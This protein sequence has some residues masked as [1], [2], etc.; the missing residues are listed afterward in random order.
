M[1]DYEEKLLRDYYNTLDINAEEVP[2][3][4]LDAVIRNGIHRGGQQ[5]PFL[6]R[7]STVVVLA[8]FAAI[9]FILVPWLRGSFEPV[10][11]QL[12]PKSWGELEP[13]RPLVK[14]NITIKSALDAGLVQEIGVSSVES[15]DYVMTLDGV[16][17]DKKGI[18]AFYTFQNNSNQ[19]VVI[20]SFL[21]KNAVGNGIENQSATLI[22]N[23]DIKTEP[24]VT[25]MCVEYIWGEDHDDP[26]EPK[27]WIANIVVTPDTPEAQL[28]SSTKYRTEL[29]VPF[30][31]KSDNILANIETVAINRSMQ[32]AGQKIEVQQAY[33]SPT[34]IYVD[35]IYD[36]ANTMKIFGL[37][38]PT[39][40]L[41]KG[42]NREVLHSF[43][44]SMGQTNGVRT[45]RFQNDNMNPDR[46]MALEI[47]G[48]EAIE[49]SKR[50]LVIDTEQRKIIKAPDDR[51][52]IS[53]RVDPDRPWVLILKL[54]TPKEDGEPVSYYRMSLDNNFA[55]GDGSGHW[56]DNPYDSYS[57]YSE[58]HE[59]DRGVT[60]TYSIN[61]GAEKLPQPLTFTLDSYPNP[62][63]EKASLRIR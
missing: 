32:I 15:K 33:I 63:R 26:K 25:R 62:F 1:A 5:K 49:R 54:F 40:I 19:N 14:D 2:E 47:D 36:K 55:D 12:P 43:G 7:R 44:G 9:L 50:E 53:D 39:I 23:N 46:R 10:R 38:S 35:I 27:S 11:A 61:V 20:S 56:L 60:S 3:A 31:L 58:F 51:L 22:G 4:R 13:F 41:G 30:S 45:L 18:V 57:T 8:A 28:S 52:T 16:L 29:Q 42:E 6:R 24:G 59:D 34:G 21:L 17:A 37:I 48:I